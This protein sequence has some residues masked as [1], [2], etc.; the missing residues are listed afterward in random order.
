[1]TLNPYIKSM[2]SLP[3]ATRYHLYLV[4]CQLSETSTFQKWLADL[5]GS[6][7]IALEARRSLPVIILDTPSHAK[8]K[9]TR[10]KA[11]DGWGWGLR[12]AIQEVEV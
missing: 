5:M 4:E 1:M 9:V 6:Y 12:L 3:M 10:L 7:E 2:L 11:L 8:A